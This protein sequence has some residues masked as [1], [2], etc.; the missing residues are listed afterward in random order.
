M[1]N[2]GM[3]FRRGAKPVGPFP[4]VPG[5][6]R[7]AAVRGVRAASRWPADVPRRAVGYADAD[8]VTATRGV[9]MSMEVR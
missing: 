9:R 1:L 8:R 6:A 2:R 7:D 4:C 5:A 3:A